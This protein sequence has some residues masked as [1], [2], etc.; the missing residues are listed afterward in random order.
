MV[1]ILHE[2]PFPKFVE[3]GALPT[4][5]MQRGKQLTRNVATSTCRE[6][7]RTEIFAKGDTGKSGELP[8]STGR[9]QQQ[10][11]K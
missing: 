7:L 8:A 1:L 5:P 4:L 10:I 3:L 9:D 11:E 2:N 6:Q